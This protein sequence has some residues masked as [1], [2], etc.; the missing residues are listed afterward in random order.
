MPDPSEATPVALITGASSGIGRAAAHLFAGRG[1]AV[2]LADVA[3]PP[4][5]ALARELTLTGHTALFVPCDICDDDQVRALVDTIDT[6]FGRLDRVFS[7]AGTE[8]VSAPL[9][10]LDD[11]GWSR[12]L[13][14]NLTGT[15]RCMRHEIPLMVRGGGAIVNNASIAGLVGFPGAAAYTASKHGVVGLTRAAALEWATVGIRV[16]AICPGLVETPMLTRATGAD[17]AALA[18]LVAGAPVGRL[19]T[20]QEIA[21]A[22]W[23]LSDPS[24]AYVTGAALPVDGGWTAR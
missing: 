14:I 9:T 4:G 6:R 21:E 23:W 1:C 8:G 19:A 17:P 2:V 11:D 15:W 5:E 18:A 10:T 16:N 7:N 13:A 24:S 3:V 12:T 20:P 22:A